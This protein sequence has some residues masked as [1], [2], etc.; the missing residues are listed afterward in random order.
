MPA[1][2]V[3][4]FITRRLPLSEVPDVAQIRLH[5][6]GASSGL[7]R[8]AEL[9]GEEF[10]TPYWPYVWAGG[11][12]LARHLLRHPEL[13]AGR[14][15]LDLGTGSGLVAIAASKAG[16]SA[17]EAI[18]PDPVALIAARLNAAANGAEIDFRLGDTASDPPPEVDLVCAGDV[19]YEP[20]LA[21][22]ALAF[23]VRCREAGAEV[24]I[25][26]PWRADLPSEWLEVLADDEVRDFGEGSGR[27]RAA[28][29]TLA[30]RRPSPDRQ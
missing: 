8:L 30:C 29:F 7:H 16:A 9:V 23:L 26:D 19:F 1:A 11:L 25:G 6:A 13:A 22:A 20:V 24:L 17:V 27:T 5:L 15:V 3:A 28:V 2:D 14:R 4:G 21:E 10:R 12:V 18:D